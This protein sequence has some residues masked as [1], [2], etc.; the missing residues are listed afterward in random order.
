MLVHC[1]KPVEHRAERVG[2]DREHR[3]QA[4][5]RVHGVATADPVP[6]AEHVVDVDAELCD[7]GRVR[8][9]CDEMARDGALVVQGRDR[10]CARRLRID[11]RFERGERLRA[12]DEQRFVG[13]EPANGL[14]EV[15]AVDV[16]HEPER[17]IALAVVAQ[18]FIGHHRAEIGAADA[19]VDDVA[20]GLAGEAFPPA[21]AD[22]GTEGGHSL[23]H[24]RGRRERHCALRRGSPHRQARATRRAAPRGSP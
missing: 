5:G 1:V 18:R 24:V 14:R 16:R 17:E 10:P 20:D 8:R 11:E 19:D 12:D 15:G 23:Q 7:F 22:I 2:T 9:Y 6:E 3:R 13:C 21:A 4:D